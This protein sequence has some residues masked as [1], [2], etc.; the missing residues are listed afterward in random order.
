MLRGQSSIQN[1][2]LIAKVANRL[3]RIFDARDEIM[4]LADDFGE[5][6]RSACRRGC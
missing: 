4:E 6:Y 3:V 5:R 2:N 1:D